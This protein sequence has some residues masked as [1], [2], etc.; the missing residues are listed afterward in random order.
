M[1]TI[2]KVPIEPVYVEI[3]PEP[4]YLESGKLY[5]SKSFCLAIHLCLCG[6]GEQVVTPLDEIV[7]ET[8]RIITEMPYGYGWILT[9]KGGKVSMLPSIGNYDFPCK[10]HYIIT[11]NVANFV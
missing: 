6:C 11:N 4:E 1:K 5:I 3:I 2:K 7:T 9:D 8:K 10:S